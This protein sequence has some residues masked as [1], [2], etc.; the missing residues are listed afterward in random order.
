MVCTGN[1]GR[2]PVAELIA[3][4]HLNEIGAGDDYE[5][6]SSGTM[7]DR[8]SKGGGFPIKVMTPLIDIARGQGL[9]DVES[10]KRLDEALRNGDRE[11]IEF[12]FNKAAKEFSG[13]EISHRE[14][15][16]RDLGISGT[17]KDTRDQTVPRQNAIA[18]LPMDRKNYVPVL[19]IYEGSEYTP[20]I[21]V[22]SVLA[23]GDL[24]A[25]VANSFGLGPEVYRERIE[26]LAHEV[27]IA[28]GKVI[29]A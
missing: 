15:I 12:Y 2:S 26:Q 13:R 5:A 20:I 18:V 21:S 28:V 11:T 3:N 29:G 17:V 10:L 6:V 22:L 25:E 1:A 24:N 9:Y 16:L 19:D 14:R 27:P 7:V 23:T 8:F 4:N